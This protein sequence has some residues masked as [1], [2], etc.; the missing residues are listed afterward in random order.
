MTFTT[1]TTLLN[2]I[3]HYNKNKI[4]LIKWSHLVGHQAFYWP[5]FSLLAPVSIHMKQLW[6]YDLQRCCGIKVL[7]IRISI[8]KSEED[9]WYLLH[10]GKVRVCQRLWLANLENHVLEDQDDGKHGDDDNYLTM[11]MRLLIMSMMRMMR[12]MMTV[13][14]LE[15]WFCDRC[16]KISPSGELT[17]PSGQAGVAPSNKVRFLAV[18]DSS[19][20]DL[21]TQ[22]VSESGHF[23]F[24]ST[25]IRNAI[26]NLNKY[27]CC[28]VDTRRH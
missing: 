21:V 2:P 22:W 26:D 11:M 27:Y 6:L 17:G 28:Q 9:L 7:I 4:R 5:V 16:W 15:V 1:S 18:Q 20:G 3:T 8:E 23:W 24:Q 13:S 25:T 10:Q 14:H 12:R 19:I